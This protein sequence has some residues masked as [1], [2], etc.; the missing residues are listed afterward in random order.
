MD[1]ALE[2]FHRF[3]E[4]HLKLILKR[5]EDILLKQTERIIKSSLPS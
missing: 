5:N 4:L 3:Q 1:I 2:I